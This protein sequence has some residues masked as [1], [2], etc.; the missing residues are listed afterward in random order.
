MEQYDD[1]EG[2][3]LGGFFFVLFDVFL[4]LNENLWE[5][6]QIL[7]KRWTNK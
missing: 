6:L 3:A 1:K 2:I 4:Y 7:W 5:I